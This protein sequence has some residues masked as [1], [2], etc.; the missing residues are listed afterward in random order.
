[1]RLFPWHNRHG[2]LSRAALAPLAIAVGY[3]A[4]AARAQQ[5]QVEDIKVG[6][7]T[8][9][10]EEKAQAASRPIVVITPKTAEREHIERLEDF[11]QRVPNYRPNTHNPQTGRPA[12]RGVGSGSSVQLG[13]ESD[14]GFVVDNVFWKAVGFQWADFV[15]I[16]SFEIG[17]GPQ[18]TAFGK[19]TTVGNV[20]VRTQLP[21][22]ERRATFET[23]FANYNHIIE[24]LNVTG[25]IIDDTLAYRVSA[26]LDKGDGWIRDQV[27]G[28]DYLNNN[29]WGVRGQLL[30]TGDDVTDRLIFSYG[31]SHE[32][33][34]NNSGPFGDSFQVFANGAVAPRYSQTVFN[35]L[36]RSILTFD[37]YKP[38]LVGQ[39]TLDQRSFTVSNE[40]NVQ[41]G[42]YTL[43][44]I[45]ALG[46][47]RLLPRNSTGNQLL[48]IQNGHANNWTHQYSQ[49]LR[50]AS[51]RGQPL[52]W[53]V[54]LYSIYEKV[55]AENETIYGAD[56]ARWFGK[57]DTDPALL[58]GFRNRADAQAGNFQLA[59]YGQGTYHFD[60]DL[61]LTLGFRNSYETRYASAFG[62]QM[63]WS[64]KYTWAEV[65][66]ALRGAGGAGVFDT[67]GHTKSSNA[68]TGIINP[69]YRLNENIQVYGL[70]GRGEKAAAV[71]VN[72]RPIRP[73]GVVKGF[74][75]LFTKPETSWDYE[76]GAKTSWLDN[77]LIANV[78]LYWN[79]IYNFQSDQVNT[80]FTDATGQVLRLVYVGNVPHV[81]LRGFEFTGRWNPIERLWIN[82]SGAY[83]EA[84]YVDYEKAAPPSDWIWPVTAGAARPPITLSRSNSRWE[85]LPK[86]TFNI[87]ANYE[88]PLGPALRGLG[89]GAWAEGSLTGFAYANVAWYDKTQYSNPWSVFQY[90][91]PP[92][93]F[94]DAGFGVRTDDERYSLS[95]W[96]KNVFDERKLLGTPINNTFGWYQGDAVNPAS[97]G[98][99]A[100][101][102]TFGGTLL[103]K[104]Y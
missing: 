76:I 27:T 50:L 20:I 12:I 52:E 55:F 21:S 67:G 3:G 75:D 2:L 99:P 28:A 45:S 49:E 11:A 19:N 1:M 35:R 18:G 15:D 43:T 58:Q 88:H 7:E 6:R 14:T 68:L 31:A 47:F 22:F 40:A 24:K 30:F 96:A 101:P 4:S 84:R 61:A 26:Y 37:P 16:D 57:P 71:N 10:R 83:T 94:V 59:G 87:G 5:V 100:Q 62:W 74:Q 41:I 98:L 34:N 42:D 82:L 56:A 39:G 51:P 36:G 46:E 48:D 77:K 23:S 17:L 65:D 91:Q 70:V 89:L 64:D 53:Q 38:Y 93:A 8:S 79:D 95:V 44:S 73:G 85:F 92:F 29:R 78:N 33:N 90:W 97:I 81:R 66:A 103:V 60:D 86:W 9:V 102:R 104:L 63:A 25:P 80:D 69:Q 32:F 54:G 13:A 72:A